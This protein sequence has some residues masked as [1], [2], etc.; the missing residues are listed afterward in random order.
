VTLLAALAQVTPDAVTQPFWDACRRREL[1]LQRCADCG[2]FRQPPQP[3]CVHCGSPRSDWPLLPGTGSVFSWTV[4]H[5]AATPALT[6]D[7]PYVVVVVEPDGA[8][9]ARLISN[10]LDP[11]AEIP[12]GLR[13]A[14]VWDEGGPDLVLPRFRVTP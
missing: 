3:G 2:R 5:H 14:V 4:V 1:R 12:I 6:P 11:P 13:V 9:G 10:L 8:P 7:V